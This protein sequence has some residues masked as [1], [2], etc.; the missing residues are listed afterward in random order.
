MPR[1]APRSRLDQS[2]SGASSRR[3]PILDPHEPSGDVGP[4]EWA[5]LNTMIR[6]QHIPAC[7]MVCEDGKMVQGDSDRLESID[8]R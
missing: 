1:D 5:R 4:V 7:L 6:I 2:T 3:R 8:Y